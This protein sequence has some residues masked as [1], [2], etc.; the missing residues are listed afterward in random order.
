M[1]LCVCIRIIF[2]VTYV[3]QISRV[4]RNLIM[5]IQSAMSLRTLLT[6]TDHATHI[7]G[8]TN[9]RVRLIAPWPL[10]PWMFGVFP[11]LSKESKFVICPWM[12]GITE[13]HLSCRTW[14]GCFLS[15][16][17]FTHLMEQTGDFHLLASRTMKVGSW[18]C[19]LASLS[20]LSVS[21]RTSLVGA[22][23]CLH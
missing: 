6:L 21:R 3:W 19:M 7:L 10:L 4:C 12:R 18:W 22:R 17:V 1:Q 11:A 2:L 9:T 8:N 14:G 13:T 23:R 16:I 15:I 5:H 20:S